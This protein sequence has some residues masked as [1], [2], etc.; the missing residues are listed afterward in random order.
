[1]II[2]DK[3][4]VKSVSLCGKGGREA[5]LEKV[6]KGCVRKNERLYDAVQNGIKLEFKKQMDLQWFD[7]GKYHDLSDK[8]R[9]IQMVFVLTHKQSQKNKKAGLIGKIEKIFTISLGD[10]LD[11]LTSSKTYRKWGWEWSNRK[12]CHKQK[13]KYPTQQAKIKIEVRKFLRENPSKC[14]VIWER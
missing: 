3:T 6:F 1:M 13:K 2:I 10:M 8:D 7:A 5:L 14:S 12:A 11:T 4:T 9:A